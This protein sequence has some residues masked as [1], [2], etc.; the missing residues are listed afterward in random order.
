MT[1]EVLVE[2]ANVGVET[3]LKNNVGEATD[4]RRDVV[5]K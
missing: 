1:E 3:N 2:L 4:A 5:D